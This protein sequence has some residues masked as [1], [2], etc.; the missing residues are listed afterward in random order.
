MK[1]EVIVVKANKLVAQ[2]SNTKT[3][4]EVFDAETARKAANV[5]TKTNTALETK[6]MNAAIHKM[7]TQNIGLSAENFKQRAIEKVQSLGISPDKNKDLYEVAV[8]EEFR[9]LLRNE[10]RKVYRFSTA[11]IFELCGVEEENFKYALKKLKDFQSNNVAQIVEYV[12]NSTYDGIEAKISSINPIPR[13]TFYMEDKSIEVELQ[14]YAV[15]YLFA[16]AS[17][18]TKINILETQNLKSSYSIKLYELAIMLF[19]IQHTKSYRIDEIQAIFGTKYKTAV[20]F[21]RNVLNKAIEEVNEKTDLE[22]FLVKSRNDFQFKIKRKINL[23]EGEKDLN[24]KDLS[25]FLACEQFFKNMGRV[26]AVKD[27][28]KYKA[29]ILKILQEKKEEELEI[30]YKIAEPHFAAILKI[31]KILKENQTNYTYDEKYMVVRTDE[32]AQN[33]YGFVRLGDNPIECLRELEKFMQQTPPPLPSPLFTHKEEATFSETKVE[34]MNKKTNWLEEL[35]ETKKAKDPDKI[36]NE[37][38]EMGSFLYFDSEQTRHIIDK[39]NINI[40]MNEIVNR[41]NNSRDFERFFS[42]PSPAQKLLFVKISN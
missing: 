20:E 32:L 1:K 2:S 34:A 28:E 18:F 11:E 17:G 42:F 37:I 15:P 27:F 4:V 8:E 5:L 3:R 14:S 41:I 26:N 21:R 25:H 35:I 13:I 31:Q 29:G 7:Q 9:V 36:L 24:I 30:E 19:K 16:L 40:F 38:V 6:L 10:V 33:D 23:T 22:I 12:P 39:S